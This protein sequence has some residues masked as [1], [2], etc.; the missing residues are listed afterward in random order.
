MGDYQWAADVGV[1]VFPRRE[2]EYRPL[3]TTND[4]AVWEGPVRTRRLARE[5]RHGGEASPSTLTGEPHK[6]REKTGTK[7]KGRR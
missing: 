1:L 3:G 6:N 4:G 2:T 7:E 5:P